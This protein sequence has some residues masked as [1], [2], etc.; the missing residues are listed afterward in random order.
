MEESKRSIIKVSR[1]VL[2]IIALISILFVLYNIGL[3][4]DGEDLEVFAR[5]E[6]I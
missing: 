4:T 3:Y 5:L 1:I 2:A 6:N